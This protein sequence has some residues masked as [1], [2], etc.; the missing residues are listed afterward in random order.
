MSGI[1]IT[2]A[3]GGSLRAMMLRPEMSPAVDTM[4]KLVGSGLP[5]KVVVY[6][7]LGQSWYEN[8]TNEVI[9][10]YW[11]EKVPLRFQDFTFE[12]VRRLRTKSFKLTIMTIA[13]C[14]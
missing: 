11:N 6:G 12:V 7:D 3:Y 1:L 9:R 13:F 14:R 10:A 5:W 8:S 4:E 2:A